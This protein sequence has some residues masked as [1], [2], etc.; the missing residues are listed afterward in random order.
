MQPLYNTLLCSHFLLLVQNICHVCKPCCNHCIIL[1]Y[2]NNPLSLHNI[3][4]IY[5][6]KTVATIVCII[7]SKTIPISLHDILENCIILQYT[8]AV[9]I[10]MYKTVAMFTLKPL[11]NNYLLC[12]HFL[13]MIYRKNTGKILVQNI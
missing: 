11:Y 9:E 10:Y 12:S 4:E 6:F 13:R 1:C 5:W 2:A 7:L 3:L 8:T